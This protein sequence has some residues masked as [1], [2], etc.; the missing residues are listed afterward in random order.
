M[1][2]LYYDESKNLEEAKAKG[3]NLPFLVA[4]KNGNKISI[5][6]AVNSKKFNY[7]TLNLYKILK[8]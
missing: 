8:F 7:F 4:F 5:Q 3:T 6:E 1:V 2:K